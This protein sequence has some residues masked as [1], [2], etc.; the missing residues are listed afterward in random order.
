MDSTFDVT[1]GQKIARSLPHRVLR[2]FETGGVEYRI[3]QIVS[4]EISSKWPNLGAMRSTGL[5]EIAD[6]AEFANAAESKSKPK[7]AAKSDESIF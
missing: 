5:V 3:G 2:P 1:E 4:P 6:P 7:R